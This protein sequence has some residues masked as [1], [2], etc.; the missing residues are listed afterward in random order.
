VAIAYL[1]GADN[2]PVRSVS[3]AY[4][5]G[6]M[7]QP[8]NST[9]LHLADYPTW[10]ADNGCFSPSGKPFDEERWWGWLKSNA[11]HASTC[12]FATAP[13]VVGDAA[14]T[15]VRSAP[16]LPRIRQLGYPAAFVAQD[17]LEILDVPWDTFDVLFLGGSTSWKLSRHAHRL[18]NRARHRG[19]MV[20]MGRVNSYR[21]LALAAAWGCESADGTYLAYGPEANLPKLLG[22]LDRIND[23]P[24]L[25]AA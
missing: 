20:H 25:V 15:L 16:W 8:G 6:L 12:R 13:D 24:E 5:I 9:H 17:G 4:N 23:T 3:L 18:V 11:S 10:A 21:R 7:S 22:W 14:A 1:T 2:A 19:K